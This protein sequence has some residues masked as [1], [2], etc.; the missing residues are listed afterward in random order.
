M[1]ER[2]R[3]EWLEMNAKGNKAFID[4]GWRKWPRV[5]LP[6]SSRAGKHAQ[7]NAAYYSTRIAPRR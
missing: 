7:A 6:A 4:R 2:D 1:N 5:T 3:L